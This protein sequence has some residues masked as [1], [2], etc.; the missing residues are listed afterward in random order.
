MLRRLTTSL[1]FAIG[2]MVSPMAA[3]VGDETISLHA[4]A[5][6]CVVA[7]RDVCVVMA[8]TQVL[9]SMDMMEHLYKNDAAK[10]A[11]FAELF[12]VSSFK[13]LQTGRPAFRKFL[14]ENAIW[15]LDF[16]NERF[17]AGFEDDYSYEKVRHN[18]AAFQ[19]LRAQACDELNNAPCAESALWSLNNTQKGGHWDD[20][21][22][23]FQM[24]EE[25]AIQ[26]PAKMLAEY[27]GR[28]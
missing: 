9:T 23:H 19:L 8:S 14:A 25:L 21:V 1:S 26:L 12:E 28:I 5:E 27:K 7:K 16:Y 22:T 18:Y 10:L 24:K 3:D 4:M 2:L 17:R 20:V 15:T 6:D 11:R 13:T